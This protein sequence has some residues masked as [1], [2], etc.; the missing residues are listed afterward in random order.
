MTNVCR[1]GEWDSGVVAQTHPRSEDLELRDALVERRQLD[2]EWLADGSA[3]VRSRSWVGIARFSDFEVVVTPKLVRGELNVLAMYDF[4]AGLD[5]VGRLPQ[6]RRLAAGSTHLLDLVSHLLALEAR[7]LM[8]HGLYAD[9]RTDTDLLPVL[10]GRLRIREQV[11]RQFGRVD[12]L[13]CAFQEHDTDNLENQLVAAGLIAASRVAR[14]PDVRRATRNL[15]AVFS[16]A[17]TVEHRPCDY[18]RV[19]IS[20][21]RRNEPYRNAHVLSYLLLEGLALRDLYSAGI[22]RSFAFLLDMNILFERFVSRL[23]DDALRGT[24]IRVHAQRRDRSVI[25]HER[26]GRSYGTVIPDLLLEHAG[27]RLPGDAKYKLYDERRLDPTDIYQV[28]MYA[29]A[30]HDG[31]EMPT[32]FLAYPSASPVGQPPRLRVRNVLGASSGRIAGWAIDV[33]AALDS[34]A[35]GDTRELHARVRDYVLALAG[36]ASVSESLL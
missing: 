17:C 3:R 24:G 33:P 10:R 29:Y 25:V 36:S 31:L 13:D 34:L 32:A 16:E 14:D 5:L 28:F 22:P 9:Y 21:T 6:E 26:T 8:D 2:V 18:Y 23:V 20:Y 35:E 15:A 11:T 7:S 27:W 1:L 4:V 12:V 19:R 30:F